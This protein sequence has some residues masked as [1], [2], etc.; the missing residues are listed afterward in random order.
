MTKEDNLMSDWIDVNTVAIEIK[1]LW[2]QMAE[3]DPK[4]AEF[5]IK[6]KMIIAF[7]T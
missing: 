1:S 2:A 6:L 4:I 7:Y 3:G 5:C